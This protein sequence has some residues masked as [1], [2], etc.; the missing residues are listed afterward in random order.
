MERIS[1]TL[2]GELA[3]AFSDQ[4]DKKGYTNRSEAIRD[5]IRDSLV[6]EEWCTPGAH[7][8]A[9][10][11]LVYD[12]HTRLLGKKLTDVQHEHEELIVSTLHVHLDHHNCL[13]VIVLRGEAGKVQRLAE[14][15]RTFR[16]VKYSQICL[17]TDGAALR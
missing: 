6:Q 15:L 2:P 1:I 10:L 11:T 14:K 8:A 9:T 5:L 16:G 13:E 17:A 4:C 7:V 12:H 3:Q